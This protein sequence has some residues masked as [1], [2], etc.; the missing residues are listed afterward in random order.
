PPRSHLFPYT[1]LF[2]SFNAKRARTAIAVANS[3]N[4]YCAQARLKIRE[5]STTLYD[6]RINL[7]EPEVCAST[8]HLNCLQNRQSRRADLRHRSEEH[9]SELQSLAYL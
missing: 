1:T 8:D 5:E 4:A 7:A 2:R 3:A 6:I 9:T